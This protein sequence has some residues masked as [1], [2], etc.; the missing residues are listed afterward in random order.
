MLEK[1]S[2][3]KAIYSLGAIFA[4][5]LQM[6]NLYS[7]FIK[8][9][10]SS[11]TFMHLHTNDSSYKVLAWLARIDWIPYLCLAVSTKTCDFVFDLQ[12]SVAEMG[13]TVHNNCIPG[14]PPGTASWESD[15]ESHCWKKLIKFQLNLAKRHVR[16]SKVWSQQYEPSSS[17][18]QSFLL[19]DLD[20]S[21]TLNTANHQKRT[22]TTVQ[23]GGFL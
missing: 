5:I 6:L 23:H 2:L 7:T 8:T 15:R 19:I 21:M 20:A 4:K 22:I 17:W 18:L 13:E 1:A 9:P 14:S 11:F 10:Y 3:S 16:D 12:T